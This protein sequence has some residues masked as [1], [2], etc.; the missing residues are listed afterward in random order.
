M[1][2]VTSS[3]DNPTF[4]V[5]ILRPSGTSFKYLDISFQSQY[6]IVLASRCIVSLQ[7]LLCD[8]Q[9][10]TNIIA[11]LAYGLPTSY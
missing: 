2:L 5:A 11:M 1:C 6:H 3:I 8:L 10:A 4:A 9:H 7:S